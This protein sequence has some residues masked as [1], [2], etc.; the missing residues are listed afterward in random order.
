MKFQDKRYEVTEKEITETYDV[1]TKFKFS[2]EYQVSVER[3]LLEPEPTIVSGFNGQT[4]P[5]NNISGY[6]LA[7]IL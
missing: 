3:E 7:P 6:Y 2:E 4:L 1:V 5:Q